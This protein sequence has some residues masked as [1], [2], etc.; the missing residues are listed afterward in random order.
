MIPG[1]LAQEVAQ[2]LR[3]FIVTG[4]ETETWPFAGEFE[5]LVTTQN[6]GEA[7]IKGPGTYALMQHPFNGSA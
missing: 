6:D 2:S 7:F 5:R 1:L 3:E 4:F